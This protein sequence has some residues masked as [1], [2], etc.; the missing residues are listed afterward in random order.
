MVR[1]D[2][3]RIEDDITYSWE[4][5]DRLL[6]HNQVIKAVPALK[7]ALLL[8]MTVCLGMR[9]ILQNQT[10]ESSE[11]AFQNALELK[12]RHSKSTFTAR[13]RSIWVSSPAP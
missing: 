11:I 7:R 8:Q 1:V 6:H 10:T 2:L 3:Y 4:I 12:S 5:S 9:Y 13:S